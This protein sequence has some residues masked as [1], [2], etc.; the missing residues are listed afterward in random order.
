[1]AGAASFIIGGLLH[2]VER[3]NPEKNPQEA[4]AYRSSTSLAGRIA[5]AWLP[6][7]Q[8]IV[9]SNLQLA[10]AGGLTE[11]EIQQLARA[12]Y[13]HFLRSFRE[14]FTLA[15]T[16]AAQRAKLVRIERPEI[17]FKALEG[18]RGLLLFGGHTGSWS[19]TLPAA[20]RQYPALRNRIS[21]LLRPFRPAWL[22]RIFWQSFRQAGINVLAKRGSMTTILQ[23]LAANQVVGFVMDQHAAPK[24]GVQVNFFGR[25]AWTFR[26][27]AVVA[28]RS[29]AAVVPVAIWR[30]RDGQ[31][32]FRLEEPLPPVVTADY[33]DDIRANTQMYNDALE[34]IIRR[35][36]EQWIWTHRRWKEG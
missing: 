2:P 26:S 21:I 30:E 9:L 12:F 4:I 11:A 18:R 25:P 23:R 6:L 22:R 13:A 8:D 5:Y 36:P 17:F 28:R 14:F 3:R 27:L 1:M 19:V 31:H 29:G 32:V 10:F 15:L 20:I 35:H 34:R 24:E 33:D 16:P 7:R